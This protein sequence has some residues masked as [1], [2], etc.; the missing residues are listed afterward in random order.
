MTLSSQ[1]SMA[2]QNSIVDIK[3]F[4][5]DSDQPTSSKEFKVFWE[6]LTEEEKNFYHSSSLVY[7]TTLQF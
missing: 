5:D 2:P 6:S 3:R 4:F 1:S 7:D